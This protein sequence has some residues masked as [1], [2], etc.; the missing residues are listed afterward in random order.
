MK[1]EEKAAK[2]A[3]TLTPEQIAKVTPCRGAR[4]A[5]I[6]RGEKKS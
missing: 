3:N 6:R 2:Q 1:G 4:R 5:A